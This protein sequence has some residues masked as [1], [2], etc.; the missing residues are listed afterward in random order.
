MHSDAEIRLGGGAMESMAEEEV[1]MIFLQLPVY[2]E[3]DYHRL[4]RRD[5]FV[6]DLRRFDD[7]IK[8][9]GLR[10]VFSNSIGNH[11]PEI[12]EALREI[13][14][15]SAAG[16]LEEACSLFPDG[17]PRVDREARCEQMD[18]I[19]D[20]LIDLEDAKLDSYY[21][22]DIFPNLLEYWDRNRPGHEDE[23]SPA[24]C[25]RCGS[26][27]TVRLIW[28]CLLL[29]G[30]DERDVDAGS[31]IVV[32]LT[33][34]I[35]YDYEPWQELMRR[36]GG[37]L[38]RWACLNCSPGWGEV[39]QM[40]MQDYRRQM[41]KIDALGA[42]QFERATALRDAQYRDRERFVTAVARMLEEANPS[43]RES[44]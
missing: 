3:E 26:S 24:A 37:V 13:G 11:W 1:R 42:A 29:R 19:I 33:P 40:A 20:A 21:Q 7:D 44:V 2:S 23:D 8:N 43:G 34:H 25:P 18:P 12:L 31:A 10:Q 35:G 15:E 32:T 9:G 17:R 39:H 14:E 16:L 27:R 28:R 4:P 22:G 38:P 6:W 41:D 30:K 36:R 5:R